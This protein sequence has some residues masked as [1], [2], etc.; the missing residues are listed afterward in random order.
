M[1]V[2]LTRKLADMLDGVDLAHHRVGDVFNATRHA[3]ELLIAEGWAERDISRRPQMKGTSIS[4]VRAHA[5]DRGSPGVLT[6][7]L[8]RIRQ[9]MPCSPLEAQEHCRAED[10]VPEERDDSRATTIPP[11]SA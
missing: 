1:R 11:K 4:S 6:E 8:R 10:R 3:A 7:R 9:P 5:A 2:R